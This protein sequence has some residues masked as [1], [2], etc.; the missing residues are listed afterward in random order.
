MW[1]SHTE[2]SSSLLFSLSLLS[3]GT[4]NV[5]SSRCLSLILV[6]F[7]SSPLGEVTLVNSQK[8]QTNNQPTHYPPFSVFLPLLGD[9]KER[10]HSMAYKPLRG[11]VSLASSSAA[12]PPS[13]TG[14]FSVWSSCLSQSLC[15]YCFL[16]LLSSSVLLAFANMHPTLVLRWPLFLCTQSAVCTKGSVARA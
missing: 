13:L 1:V 6:F 12:C 15:T 7:Q 2:C 11:P 4:D 9:R 16:Y 14:L 3:E 8:R 10:S 5:S